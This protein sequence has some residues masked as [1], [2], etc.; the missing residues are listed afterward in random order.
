MW[1]QRRTLPAR[2][3]G[4]TARCTTSMG[5]LTWS[6]STC[7]RSAMFLSH[8]L[9]QAVPHKECCRAVNISFGYSFG[10]S[11]NSCSGYSCSTYANIFFGLRILVPNGPKNIWKSWLL[12]P[13]NIRKSCFRVP[14]DHMKILAP[15]TREYMI[16]IY[17]C[18]KDHMK[19]YFF[20]F[21]VCIQSITGFFIYKWLFKSE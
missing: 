10:F 12:V 2:P 8:S 5:R 14:K 13:K 17:S 4:T 15:V 1:A 19:I 3:R 18:T 11:S 6:R 7:A 20:Y 21:C 16:I 9:L